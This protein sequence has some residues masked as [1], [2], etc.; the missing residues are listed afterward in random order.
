MVHSP[1]TKRIK[2]GIGNTREQIQHQSHFQI[3]STDIEIMVYMNPGMSR[4]D[5]LLAILRNNGDL[6]KTIVEYGQ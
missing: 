4:K 2:I 3:N 5:A 1:P 6:S